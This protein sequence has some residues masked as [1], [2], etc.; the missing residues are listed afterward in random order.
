M[1]PPMTE[2]TVLVSGAAG[3]IGRAVAERFVS[4]GDAVA[5][6]D[7]DEERLH[8]AAADLGGEGRRLATVVADVR[9]VAA[10]ESMVAAVAAAFGRLDVLVNCAGVWVEGPTERATEDEW[11]RTV[12]V[13]LKG[14][15]FS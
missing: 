13:N 15:F 14:T 6:A 1:P 5:L 3:G 2:R 8:T 7:V 10:C 12:D 9:S 4:Q 11:D